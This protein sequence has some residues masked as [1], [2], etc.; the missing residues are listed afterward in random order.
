MLPFDQSGI[1]E[2]ARFTNYPIG[3]A[4][5]KQIKIVQSPGENKIKGIEESRIQLNLVNFIK[6]VILKTRI[7]NHF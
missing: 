1:I 6:N 3:K 2:Q 5:V 7:S 4:S